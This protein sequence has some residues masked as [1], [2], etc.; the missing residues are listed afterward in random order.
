M[1]LFDV[2]MPVKNGELF[3]EHAVRSIQNQS[4]KDWRLL[5]LDH[6]STD[7]TCEIVQRM[8]RQ[9]A[10]IQ[11]YAFPAAKGLAGLLNEGLSLIEAPYAMRMDADDE[12][13]PERMALTITEFERS[14]GVA[15]VGGQAVAIDGCGRQIGRHEVPTESEVLGRVSLFRNPFV[16]PA[17]CLRSAVVA[18]RH[19]RY[20]H[21]LYADQ[22]PMADIEVPA[23]AE[24]YLLFAELA[25]EGIASNL[26]CD[27]LRYRHHAGGVSR[28]K[29][30]DQLVVSAAISRHLAGLISR[31]VGLPVF[32]PAPFCT[33]GETLLQIGEQDDYVHHYEAM[34]S[35]LTRCGGVWRNSILELDWRRTFIDRSP[36]GILGRLGMRWARCKPSR[37]ERS[38]VKTA[39]LQLL[40]G[41]ELVAV[42]EMSSEPHPFGRQPEGFVSSS[43]KE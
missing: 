23:L 30:H 43:G 19:I 26:G 13:L 14:P 4:V 35:V 37:H 24:D 34:V 5:V 1:P 10:R 9:D 39:T 27:L 15:L 17:V 40:R 22:D 32:D 12:S 18:D 42:P 11:L 8:A 16:H 36:L 2:L 41:K 3:L 38:A 7:S 28:K 21:S 6:G 29:F 25:S 33:H 31:R 20:G